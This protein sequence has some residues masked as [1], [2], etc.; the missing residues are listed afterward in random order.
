MGD[1]VPLHETEPLGSVLCYVGCRREPC[2]LHE[3]DFPLSNM[4]PMARSLNFLKKNNFTFALQNLFL[5]GVQFHNPS[6]IQVKQF[7]FAKDANAKKLFVC[8][9]LA[10]SLADPAKPG[11]DLK[12]K[13]LLIY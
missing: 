2:D 8:Q 11:A 10:S 12:T 13:S 7:Q 3:D 9:A 5:S 4:E 1:S 6:F